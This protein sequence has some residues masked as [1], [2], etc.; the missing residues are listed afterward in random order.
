MIEDVQVKEIIGHKLSADDIEIVSGVITEILERFSST[1]NDTAAMIK[2]Y[3]DLLGRVPFA[4][5]CSISLGG[6]PIIVQVT[7]KGSE[8]GTCIKSIRDLIRDGHVG[9]E[10]VGDEE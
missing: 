4:I 9:E 8:I 5:T 3:K 1:C 7:G 6:E 10:E 2:Q